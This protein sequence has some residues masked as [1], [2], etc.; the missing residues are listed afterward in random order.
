MD[1]RPGSF[2]GCGNK[3]KRCIGETE[4]NEYTYIL[5]MLHRGL[6]IDPNGVK[7]KSK[8]GKK[9][10][11]TIFLF[12]KKGEIITCWLDVKH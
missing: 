5:G 4:K 12:K 7:D 10:N 11:K 6:V 1:A 9:K 2:V 3:K 8:V